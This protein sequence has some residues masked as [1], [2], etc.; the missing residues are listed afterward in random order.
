LEGMTVAKGIDSLFERSY[1]SEVT[2]LR[3]DRAMFKWDCLTFLLHLP[4]DHNLFP[5]CLVVVCFM[6]L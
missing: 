3:N 6:T 2:R 4:E 1:I 5:C